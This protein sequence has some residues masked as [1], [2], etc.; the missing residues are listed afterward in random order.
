MHRPPS[1]K[2][3][4]FFLSPF[5]ILSASFPNPC[6]A[7]CIRFTHHKFVRFESVRY[8]DSL[9]YAHASVCVRASFVLQPST[10]PLLQSFFSSL[11]SALYSWAFSAHSI[12]RHRASFRSF[13]GFSSFH[14]KS[15]VSGSL[16]LQPVSLS[17]CRV[18]SPLAMSS[19]IINSVR[20][21]TE[22]RLCRETI[23][24]ARLSN[25]V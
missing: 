22:P 19:S 16:C 10:F 17:S 2:R 25:E 23:C 12:H 8:S 5:L 3:A 18:V 7:F 4:S 15:S 11:V 6:V 21:S 20:I 24:A 13:P 9:P 14:S 1:A